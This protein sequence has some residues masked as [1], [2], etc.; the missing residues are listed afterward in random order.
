[1]TKKWNSRRLQIAQIGSDFH[2]VI[3]PASV[4][5]SGVQGNSMCKGSN[6]IMFG[7]I[8]ILKYETVYIILSDTTY[9]HNIFIAIVNL[10]S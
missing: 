9:I 6:D 2:I 5:I 4:Q 1:M 8:L 10:H 3:Y 7:Y